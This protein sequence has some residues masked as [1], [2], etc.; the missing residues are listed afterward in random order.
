ML[1]NQTLLM[2][3][4]KDNT[5]R[6]ERKLRAGEADRLEFTY[7]KLE[8]V[9]A[10]KNYALANFALTSSISELENV[11]QAP[12]LASRI[13]SDKLEQLSSSNIRE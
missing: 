8:S 10:E 9:V 6:I 4:Q 12:L 13:K 7:A 1:E 3:Q 2:K 5:S 11:I